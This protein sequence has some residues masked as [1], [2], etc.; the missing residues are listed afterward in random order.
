[1]KP[2]DAAPDGDTE[3]NGAVDRCRLLLLALACPRP[4][5]RLVGRGR[6]KRSPHAQEVEQLLHSERKTQEDVVK[7]EH[8]RSAQCPRRLIRTEGED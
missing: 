6:Q 2:P 4:D 5:G 7:L 1:V 3:M 8:L